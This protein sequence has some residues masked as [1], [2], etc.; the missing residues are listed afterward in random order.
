MLLSIIILLLG[1]VFGLM[2]RK[3][4]MGNFAVCVKLKNYNNDTVAD[5]HRYSQ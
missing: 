4:K 1:F 5:I 2:I 3:Y